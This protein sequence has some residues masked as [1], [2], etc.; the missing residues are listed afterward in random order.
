MFLFSSAATEKVLASL[1]WTSR[2]LPDDF[3]FA[4]LPDNVLV[5]IGSVKDYINS[6]TTHFPPPGNVFTVVAR[7]GS[8]VTSS[9][10]QTVY[11]FDNYFESETP[12]RNQTYERSIN[13]HS[14]TAAMWPPYCREGLY[15]LPVSFARELYMESRRMTA[16]LSHELHDVLVTGILRRKTRRG[17]VNISP[18]GKAANGAGRIL[19]VK[20]LPRSIPAKLALFELDAE[21]RFKTTWVEWYK[22]IRNRYHIL[23]QVTPL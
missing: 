20:F 13:V 16:T 21:D 7:D 11:C 10:P 6:L 23:T 12:E 17:D 15:T 8:T 19:R 5:N 1:S 3:Y 18:A 9:L 14:Y 22:S 4:S 2:I